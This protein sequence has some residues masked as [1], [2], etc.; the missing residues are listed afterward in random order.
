M[1][2]LLNLFIIVLNILY[3]PIKLFK[4]K[5]KVVFLS[6]QSNDITLDFRLLAESI[7]KKDQKIECVFL[8][9]RFDN[10]KK[11]LISYSL[12][13]IKS[14]YHIATSKV[15]IVD[16]Y[17]IVS[18]LHNKKDLKILQIWHS[19]GAIKKFSYQTIGT[20]YGRNKDVAEILKMHYGYDAIITSSKENI[21]YFKQAF[22]YPENKFLSY[23]LPRI[24]YLL[25]E[26]NNIKNK[27]L[28]KYPDLTK[29][30]VI[31]YAPTFRNKMKDNTDELIKNIDLNKYNLIIKNHL[32]Q[33]LN[34]KNDKV[35]TCD[36]FNTLDLITICDYLIT[37]YSAISLEAAILNK[38]TYY[39]LYDY[40][41][42]KQNNGLNIDLF[43]EMPGCVFKNIVDLK[44]KLESDYD[45]SLVEKYKHKYIDNLS[46]NST[47]LISNLIIEW[48]KEY[49]NKN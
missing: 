41:E 17:S 46:G 42:Y 49:D 28:N 19:L 21:K 48:I 11:H 8:C 24:D 31:L 29:K 16:S 25:K 2:I 10:I 32:N 13:V 27:I 20:K 43:K 14:M 6:R 3:L 22:N 44:N 30:K 39:Y 33:K 23:G 37:D 38:K 15:C 4:T 35:Y 5:N 1:K 45:I 47:E 18:M 26:E 12:Y 7:I 36:D 34:F 9:K 40:E